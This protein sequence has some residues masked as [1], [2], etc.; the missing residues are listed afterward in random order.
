[1]VGQTTE[2]Y[3]Y[4]SLSGNGSTLLVTDPNRWYV[5]NTTE[6][7]NS[8][9]AVARTRRLSFL[10]RFFYSYDNRYLVTAN[11]RADGSSKFPNN[12]WGYFP[13]V[14]LAW[15]V[16]QEHF[17]ENS[18]DVLDNLKLRLSW[19]QIGNDKISDGA[20]TQSI[21]QGLTFVSYPFGNTT[22]NWS[23]AYVPGAAVTTY[24]N[25]GGKWEYTEQINLGVDFGFGTANS[26]EIST[27][28]S[29]TPTIC[30]LT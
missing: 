10:G 14:A 18:K 4:Y 22:A 12:T 2:E 29:E 15:R 7:K 27:H 11:F 17:M 20:F 3:N 5:S 21:M 19:G 1:M 30:S 26:T 8:S 9:D 13:S 23:T 6:D 16:S 25:T 28:T 24:V